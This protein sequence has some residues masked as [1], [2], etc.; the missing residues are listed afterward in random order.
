MTYI[1]EIYWVCRDKTEYMN[2]LLLSLGGR[3]II[4]IKSLT[5]VY[6]IHILKKEKYIEVNMKSSAFEYKY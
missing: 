5:Q 2:I 3:D 1:N 4:F 6:Q